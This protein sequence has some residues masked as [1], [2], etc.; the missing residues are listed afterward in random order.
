MGWH[1]DMWDRLSADGTDVN[2]IFNDL[3][4]K[5]KQ[6]DQIFILIKLMRTFSLHMCVCAFVCLKTP[7]HSFTTT[8][9]HTQKSR[10][11]CILSNMHTRT[12]IQ[13]RSQITP[14][15]QSPILCPATNRTICMQTLLQWSI[16]LSDCLCALFSQTCHLCQTKTV[17]DLLKTSYWDKTKWS[18]WNKVMETQAKAGFCMCR[19]PYINQKP[20]LNANRKIGE[21]FLRQIVRVLSKCSN[22][23]RLNQTIID[24]ALCIVAELIYFIIWIGM[25]EAE[26]KNRF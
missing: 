15:P 5:Y 19:A 14:T 1:S 12:N 3:A 8:E 18:Q 13:T 22:K 11:A 25:D 23:K 17:N 21:R 10:R 24:R 7:T 26:L 4:E 16:H 9:E 6:W 20:E 2:S